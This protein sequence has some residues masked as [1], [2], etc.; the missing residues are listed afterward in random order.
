MNAKCICTVHVLQKGAAM[1]NVRNVITLVMISGMALALTGCG[2][3]PSDVCE[4]TFELAKAEVGEATAKKAIGGDMAKCVE[5]ES[6]RKER[7][8]IFK[9]KDNN[10]CLMSAKTWKDAQAC[11]S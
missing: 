9:Y 6:G 1:M 2:P 5:S 11:S 10:K 8:G 4:K 3:S 7:Q